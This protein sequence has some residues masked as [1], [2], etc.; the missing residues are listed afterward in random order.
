MNVH[1]S[2]HTDRDTAVEAHVSV[3]A[4]PGAPPFVWLDLGNGEAYIFLVPESIQALRAA[5][6]TADAAF[7]VD[8]LPAVTT[9]G[10]RS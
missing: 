3:R 10:A 5:L 7:A 8:P 1:A 6:D 9:D 4:Q 2:I